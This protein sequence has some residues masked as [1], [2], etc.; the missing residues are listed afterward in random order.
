MCDCNK[1]FNELCREGQR[2]YRLHLTAIHAA[3]SWEQYTGTEIKAYLLHRKAA[4]G[5]L[6]QLRPEVMRIM[7]PAA[8]QGGG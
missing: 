3:G 7:A 4:G 6:G 8:E 1:R 2:L 5:E